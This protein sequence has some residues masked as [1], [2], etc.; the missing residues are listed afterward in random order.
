MKAELSNKGV[1]LS[2]IPNPE[3]NIFGYY[4]YRGVSKKN[5]DMIAEPIKGYNYVDSA[6]IKNY[7]GQYVYAI[8]VMDNGQNMSDTSEVAS[9]FI[10][11]PIV[12]ASPGGLQAK[13]MAE[14][15]ELRWENTRNHDHQVIGFIVFRKEKGAQSYEI[16]NS[17]P[18]PYAQYVD[19][20][21]V[22]GIEYEYA[23]SSIDTWGNQS[24]LSPFAKVSMDV[25]EFLKPPS[26][27]S[28]RNVRDGIEISWSKPY[29]SQNRQYIIYRSPAN[30]ERFVKISS[31][32]PNQFFVDKSVKDNLLYQYKV[33]VKID[34]I[35]GEKSSAFMIR[36]Q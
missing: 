14:G 15:I 20:S 1:E 17:Q 30:Q 32:D 10:R 19:S 25:D 6:F 2:W 26:S 36:R 5:M 4:I 27:I 7:S 31:T 24:I 12:L 9:V 11:Q 33:A 3:L 13:D 22:R 16:L 29:Q 35:E 28:L 21:T 34:Q 8:Q 23:V 18:I